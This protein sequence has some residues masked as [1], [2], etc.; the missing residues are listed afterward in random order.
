MLMRWKA[1]WL[2]DPGYA[3]DMS[4][5]LETLRHSDDPEALAAA[6]ASV[7]HAVAPNH[8]LFPGARHVVPILLE[9]LERRGPHVRAEIY[10]LLT[11]LSQSEPLGN[12]SEDAETLAAVSGQVSAALPAAWRDLGSGDSQLVFAAM[13]L[14][15]FADPDKDEFAERLRRSYESFDDRC[16]RNA[17]EW[18]AELT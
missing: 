8:V 15:G 14:I 18:L 17:D 10:D 13:D 3:P 4:E 7:E 5:R 2:S 6:R 16:R 1:E 9:I 12:A 11:E